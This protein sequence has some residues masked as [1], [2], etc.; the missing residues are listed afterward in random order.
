M[1]EVNR[2]L[3]E[4]SSRIQFFYDRKAI[5]QELFEHLLDSIDDL[6]NKGMSEEEAQKQAVIQM[7]NAKQIGDELNQIHHPILGWIWWISNKIM[8]LVLVPFVLTVITQIGTTLYSLRPLEPDYKIIHAFKISEKVTLP[9]HT[10]YLRQ[11][12]LLE[13]GDIAIS[14][15]TLRNLFYSRSGWSISPFSIPESKGGKSFIT[16]S[17]LISSGIKYF[18]VNHYEDISLEFR[19]GQTLTLD[20][21]EADSWNE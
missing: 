10:V 8:I 19:D 12:F 3:D 15:S 4:V 7:G 1:N 21:M 20:F 14:Y 16:N 17:F 11:G 5:R 13:N 9:T 2:Y 6:M 18:Q